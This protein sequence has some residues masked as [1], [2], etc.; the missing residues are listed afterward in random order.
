MPTHWFLALLTLPLL[1]LSH[2]VSAQP[3]RTADSS[4]R[5]PV[6]VLPTG[7]RARVVAGGTADGRSALELR[8]GRLDAAFRLDGRLDEM[9]WQAGDSIDGLTKAEP[10]VGRPS[11]V[12][13]VVR[14]VADGTRLVVGIRADDPDPAGIVSFA[15]ARDASLA[16]EDHIKLV[17]DTYLDGRSGYVFAVNPNGARYDALVS[18]QGDA[19]DASWDTPWNAAAVR[20][21]TGWSAEIELPVRSLQF[22]Q[23]LESW[24]FNVQ[25]RVQRLLEVDRWAS[26]V[27]DIRITQMYRAGRLTNL[28]TFG[29]G[30]G[31]QVRPSLVG[32]TG[33]PAPKALRRDDGALSFDVTK[34]LGANTLAA[35]TV[36][37]DFAETEVDTR[38]TNLTRF[39]IVFPEKR[40]FFLQGADIFEF[41]LG[42]G[43]DVRPFFS[44]RIGLL[45]GTEVPIRAGVKVTG[46]GN[47]ANV[48]ALA[49]RTAEVL[50]GVGSDALP[51]TTANTLAAVRLRQNVFRESSI[52]L[53][54]SSGDPVGRRDS[55][56]AGVD[57]L[58]R[59]SRFRR[60]KNLAAAVWVRDSTASGWPTVRAWSIPMTSGTLP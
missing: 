41:G 28:P 31:L 52:G 45:D 48:G 36:N 23:G 33:I 47:G 26:P 1:A 25:R 58:F 15:R 60:D 43:T 24:G 4:R 7:E 17:F 37:T 32:G 22:A 20:T 19:E 53:L 11:A 14:V 54:A 21:E 10:V 55:W 6:E 40:T 5:A 13:T 56:T 3:G 35:L 27:R 44:R 50:D 39:P 16:A 42:L 38:R 59:T 9:M 46:R 18:G 57:A 8:A 2:T 30:V 49:L 34:T 51:R 29:L 12:R